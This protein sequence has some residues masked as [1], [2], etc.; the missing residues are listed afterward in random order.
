MT[1][2]AMV[3]NVT[4]LARRSC[5]SSLGWIKL[6]TSKT[7]ASFTLPHIYQSVFLFFC[8][9]SYQIPHK[10]YQAGFSSLLPPLLES[11]WGLRLWRCCRTW[12]VPCYVSSQFFKH[13]KNCECYP[14]H[15]LFNLN[16]KG[17]KVIVSIVVLNCQQCNQCL[18]CQVSGHKTLRLLCFED[19][20]HCLCFLLVRTCLHHSKWYY[21]FQALSESFIFWISKKKNLEK[22]R[23]FD[24]FPKNQIF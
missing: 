11:P 5:D 4:C 10:R 9:N 12:T 22:F 15:S 3:S 14:R 7:E 23:K 2:M 17:H 21:M 1:T 6:S 19:K 16:F 20:C 24:K 8:F 18:K 13:C